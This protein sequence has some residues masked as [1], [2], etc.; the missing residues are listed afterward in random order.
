MFSQNIWGKFGKS[1][2]KHP[3]IKFKE[4]VGKY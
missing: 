2:H 3:D 4:G 1:S